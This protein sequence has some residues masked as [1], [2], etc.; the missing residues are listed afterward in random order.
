[1]KRF[2]IAAL[3][4]VTVLIVVGWFAG[5]LLTAPVHRTSVSS[6]QI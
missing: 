1:V 4:V 5:T 3:I 2:V 6:R